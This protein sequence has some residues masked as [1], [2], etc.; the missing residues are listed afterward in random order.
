MASETTFKRNVWIQFEEAKTKV[1]VPKDAD[2]DDLIKEA[3]RNSQCRDSVFSQDVEVITDDGKMVDPGIPVTAMKDY[4]A[5]VKPFCL[6]FK[7][8]M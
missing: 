7:R 5:S 2:N 4:G 1:T 8:G 3:I 6:Q